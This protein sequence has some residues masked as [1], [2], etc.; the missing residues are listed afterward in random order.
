MTPEEAYEFAA[1]WHEKQAKYCLEI[2]QDDMRVSQDIRDKALAAM[3]HHN[4][5][6]VG[7]RHYASQLHRKELLDVA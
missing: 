6:A 1:Q 7:L 3:K 2:S 5:S 4:A